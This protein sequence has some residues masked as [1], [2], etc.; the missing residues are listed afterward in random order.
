MHVGKRTQAHG[1][2]LLNNEHHESSENLKVMLMPKLDLKASN[3][4]TQQGL[5]E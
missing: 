5:T 4:F 3:E 1:K 2:R